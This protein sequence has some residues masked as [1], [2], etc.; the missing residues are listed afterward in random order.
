M[1]FEQPAVDIYAP[2]RRTLRRKLDTFQPDAVISTY[3]IY[4]QLYHRV[5]RAGETHPL[6]TIIT[7]SISINRTWVAGRS[8][9]IFVT[10]PKSKQI[11]VDL[12]TPPSRVLVR[13][14]AVSP[15]FVP[16]TAPGIR[17]RST[18]DR[19]LYLPSTSARHVRHTLLSL[20]DDAP[21]HTGLTIVLGRH[22]HR[23]GW[24]VESLVQTHR[25][26]RLVEILGWCDNI[27]ELM[28]QHDAI[29]TKAGG[30][31]IHESFAAAIPPIVNSI[32]PGQEEG[33]AELVLERGCGLVID[34]ARTTGRVLRRAV[35]SGEWAGLC[36]NMREHHQ[37]DGAIAIADQILARLSRPTP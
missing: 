28:S 31:T 20:L 32:V 17:D 6:F 2:L 16:L 1:D 15:T 24:D 21:S 10:D 8:D 12:G 7:D 26:S 13:G 5:R 34:D 9:V 19:I 4:P 25:G 37:P 22:A 29:V 11:I 33:N 18:L 27:P 30:A 14:F 23:I 35:E 36:R 3:P